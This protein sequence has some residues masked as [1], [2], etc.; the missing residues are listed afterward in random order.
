MTLNRSGRQTAGVNRR[1][2]LKASL[3]TAVLV[4][5]AE[6]GYGAPARAL[7][8]ATPQKLPR[9]R[10]F[11]LLEKFHYPWNNGPFV[12]GD[13][14]W[15]SDWGFNFVRL[16][17]DC[18]CWATTP[19]AEFNEQ[20][21]KE[22][23]QAVAWGKQYGVHV[24]LNFHRSPGYCVNMADGEQPTLWTEAQAQKHFARHW[25][26]FAARY[27]GVPS[28]ELSFNLIN[29]P[30]DIT[31]PV[32]A[33]AMRPAIETIHSADPQ[34]LIIADGIRWGTTPVPEL[35][36]FGIAQSTRGYEPML[37]SHYQANWIHHD[38]PWPAPTWPIPVGINNH[39]YGD[40]K[41]EF[42]SALVLRVECPQATPFSIH[43]AQVSAQAELMVKADGAVVLQKLFQPGSGAGE[44]KKSELTA[45]GGYN[46]D[47]DRDYSATLPAGTR[48]VKIEVG[49]GDWLTFSEWRLGQ[50]IITP[51]SVDWGV[52]QEAFM[53]DALGAHPVDSRYLYSR[54]TLQQKVVEPWQALA[55]QGVGVVVGE[56]GAF[57][58]TPHAVALAWMHDCLDNWRAAGFGWSLWNFRGPFGILDSDREDVAYEVF[59]GH[60]LDRKMLELLQQF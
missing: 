21:M 12:E 20:T 9:W 4:P 22:I 29:E 56:W 59:K 34:R 30:G 8:E 16:P 57:N 40:S 32:Y 15:I 1:Q 17:M 54:E 52:K 50:I 31:G 58:R 3:A 24:C 49:Q 26:V 48:E 55:A 47:Y 41:P 25:G 7:P 44:W 43:I 53:V 35:I 39:L 51:G 33:A 46:A 38:G 18:R 11:N 23:D 10:G 27:R 28:R 60:Q 19:E 13:F 42:K 5:F 6:R 37:V 36:P 45:W 2:F 14:E